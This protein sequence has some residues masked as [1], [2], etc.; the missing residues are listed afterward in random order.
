MINIRDIF[1]MSRLSLIHADQ[2][3]RVSKSNYCCAVVNAFKNLRRRQLKDVPAENI[4]ITYAKD[5][6]YNGDDKTAAG[7]F[8][9]GSKLFQGANWVTKITRG[10]KD[11]ANYSHLIDLY[12]QHL[13]P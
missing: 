5:G 9:S 1:A 11:Y 2:L 6:W 7:P 13:N 12:N 4:L 8:A 10:T 3:P